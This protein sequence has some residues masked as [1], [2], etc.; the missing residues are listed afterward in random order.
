MALASVA[1]L[2][3]HPFV[4]NGM[5]P[6]STDTPLAG[7]KHMQ[8]DEKAST[9]PGSNNVLHVRI[10][11]LPPDAS[12]IYRG[13]SK[14]PKQHVIDANDYLVIEPLRSVCRGG[15]LF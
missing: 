4:Q 8:G 9:G 10:H 11:H 1:F 3:S 13:G 14:S 7:R 5:F 15:V 12:G 2:S 6:P